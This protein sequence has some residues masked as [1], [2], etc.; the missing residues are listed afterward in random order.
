VVVGVSPTAI[1][2]SYQHSWADPASGWATPD[3]NVP[4]TFVQDTLMLVED[5]SAGTN[6]QGHPIS[7]EGC[8]PL[9]NDLTG[10]IAVI[11]RN[12]CNFSVKALNAQNAGAVGVIIINR[13]PAVIAMGAGTDGASVTIPTIMLT[14][15]DGAALVNE[16]ANGPVV[17]FMGNKIGLFPN[18][19]AMRAGG[20]LISKSTGVLSQLSQNGTEFTFDIG[21]H[22]YN[23]GSADQTNVLVNATV[24]DPSGAAVYNQNITVASILAHDSVELYP[25]SA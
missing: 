19:A 14:S 10:K 4:G 25:G 3:F 23:D 2:G 6:A 8:N 18:D 12:T 16:M 21:T 1:V 11:Y 24:T 22:L 20:T 5:G 9:I 17:V 7:E 15:F 13:D